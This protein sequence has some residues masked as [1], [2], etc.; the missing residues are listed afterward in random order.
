MGFEKARN[1]AR[2]LEILGLNPNGAYTAAEVKHAYR[3]AALKYHPDRNKGNEKAA[4]AQFHAVNYAYEFLTD[5]SFRHKENPQNQ[6]PDVILR[7]TLSFDEGFFGT[8]FVC[9][10]SFVTPEK[11]EN[12]GYKFTVEPV[13]VVVPAGT[14]LAQMS[15]PGKGIEKDGV[16]SNVI[17]QVEQALHPKFK[18]VGMDIHVVEH[19]PLEKLLRGGTV[20]V[21]TMYGLRE[22]KIPPGTPPGSKLLLPLVGVNRQGHQYVEVQ[23]VFP[24]V[25]ELRTKDEWRGLGINWNTIT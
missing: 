22:L 11:L 24:A 25:D 8:K 7:R 23:L 9:T 18:M 20:D 12:D 13:E 14:S 4:E 15:F 2:A 5:P 6:V 16:R 21:E 1:A 17:I 10:F 19:I 3:Q